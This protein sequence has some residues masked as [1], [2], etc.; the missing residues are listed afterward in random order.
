M[1][2]RTFSTTASC[3]HLLVYLKM[4]LYVNRK[5]RITCLKCLFPI[6]QP[7]KCTFL[8]SLL[9]SGPAAMFASECR[10]LTNEFQFLLPI[11]ASE[12]FLS[13]AIDNAIFQSLHRQITE[14]KP[15]L[16]LQTK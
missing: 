8:V 1:N 5:S 7:R 11:L 4:Q 2:H 6:L 3:F 13:N 10:S 9:Y 14:M 16:K 12:N 15:F